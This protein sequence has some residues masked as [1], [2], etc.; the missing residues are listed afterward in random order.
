MRKIEF[1]VFDFFKKCWVKSW[2]DPSSQSIAFLSNSSENEERTVEYFNSF[3]GSEFVFQ[4]YTGIKDMNDKKIFEGDIVWLNYS[5]RRVDEKDHNQFE[6]IFHRGAFQL[7]PIKLSKPQGF[8]VGGGNFAFSHI[9]EII[10]HD[11]NDAP[12][13]KYILPPSR[14][15]SEFSICVVMGNI[16]ENPELLQ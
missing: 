11:Q 1:R 14:S 4:Q 5:G 15:I 12:I 8:G 10:G 7:N 13:Y 9:V 3:N 6:V 16:F 2:M